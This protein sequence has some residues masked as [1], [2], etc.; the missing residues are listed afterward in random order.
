[1]VFVFLGVL[2]PNFLR[3]RQNMLDR[4]TSKSLEDTYQFLHEVVP[5]ESENPTSVET[6]DR[7]ALVVQSRTTR[8]RGCGSYFEGRGRGGDRSGG[9]R[10]RGN[11]MSLL[12]EPSHIKYICTLL[13][14]K[15][16]QSFRSA[17]IATVQEEQS[18]SRSSIDEE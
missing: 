4:F 7:S 2:R 13:Q 11:I 15:H 9:Q 10:R 12:R 16:E 6:R 18:D 14:G 3:A 5:S 1:M 8:G 17:Y